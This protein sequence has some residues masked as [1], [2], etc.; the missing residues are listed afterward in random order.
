MS[1]ETDLSQLEEDLRIFFGP[2]AET[3]LDLW[4]RLRAPGGGK[5]GIYWVSFVAPL[6]WLL[7][8]KMYLTAAALTITPVAIG[9][10]LPSGALLKT[11]GVAFAI[12]G[13]LGPRFYVQGA[14]ATIKDIRAQAR[15]EEEAQADIGKAGGVS[16]PGALIG[17][18]MMLAGFSVT[19]L[20]Q[21]I[22]SAG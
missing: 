12:L 14:E 5:V 13:G 10:F 3:F 4:S 16:V 6:V 7:Y 17:A 18:L 20:T 19:I 15:T 2:N 9:L 22:R 8:R 1:V 21:Q 11:I